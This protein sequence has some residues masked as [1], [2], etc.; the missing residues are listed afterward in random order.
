MEEFFVETEEFQFKS[1]RLSFI[2]FD[3]LLQ[4]SFRVSLVNLVQGDYVPENFRN[5]NGSQF[6]DDESGVFEET[7]K[8]V[9]VG[10]VLFRVFKMVKVLSNR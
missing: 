1:E 3:H 5:G 8:R 6:N 7:E 4:F 2:F 10:Q 9:E